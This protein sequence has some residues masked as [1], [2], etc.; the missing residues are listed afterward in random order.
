MPEIISFAPEIDQCTIKNIY[1]LTI[2]D[3]PVI[4]ERL[5]AKMMKIFCILAHPYVKLVQIENNTTKISVMCFK[6]DY[7]SRFSNA[8][9]ICIE[10]KEKEWKN[11]AIFGTY[12]NKRNDNLINII[13]KAYLQYLQ[14]PY[15][16]NTTLNSIR[17][18][19]NIANHVPSLYGKESDLW[20]NF[21]GH[22]NKKVRVAV[23]EVIRDI[24]INI[25]VSST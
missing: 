13:F 12:E 8:N 15:N 1:T 11:Y 9:E 4:R 24:F 22:E 17:A 23:K 21:I 16:G 25:L 14:T 7:C 3:E 5:S 6:C 10:Y 2:N 20:L 19:K 18:L